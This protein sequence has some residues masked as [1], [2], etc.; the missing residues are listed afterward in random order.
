LLVKPGAYVKSGQYKV[1]PLVRLEH[2]LQTRVKRLSKLECLFMD[3][4]ITAY[5]DI[6]R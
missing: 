1:L 3:K 5:S 6:Y 2:Y 4:V